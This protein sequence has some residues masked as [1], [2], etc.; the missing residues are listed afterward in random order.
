[1][2]ALSEPELAF[3]GSVFEVAGL[4][5][6]VYERNWHV[7]IDVHFGFADNLRQELNDG[8]KFEVI[9]NGWLKL[10]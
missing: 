1:M 8:A 5:V 2:D 4:L 10:H 6:L 7:E 3:D 9:L